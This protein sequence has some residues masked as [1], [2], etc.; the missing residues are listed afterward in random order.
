MAEFAAQEL[1]DYLEKISSARVPVKATEVEDPAALVNIA[2]A[3]VIVTGED[4]EPYR[5]TASPV[6]PT[7]WLKPI[8]A[9]LSGAKEDSLAIRNT[10]SRSALA[11]TNDRGTLYAAYELLEREGVRFFAPEFDFYEGHSE[12][13]PHRST[14]EVGTLRVTEQPS[15]ALRRKFVGQGISHDTTKLAQLLDWMAKQRLNILVYPYNNHGG[16]TIKWDLY[17]EPLVPE[18]ERRSMI[19]EVGGHG[20]HSFLP[21]DEYKDEHPEWFEDGRNVFDVTNEEAVQTYIDN[22]IAYL[23]G[24]PEIKIFD[25]WPPDGARWPQKAIDEFGSIPNAEAHLINELNDQMQQRLP[26]VTVENIA[27]QPA[28]E[29]PDPEYMYDDEVIID[30]APY[31][32]SYTEPIF[33]PTYDK[34]RDF[35]ELM[36]RWESSGFGGDKAIYEY[37][38]KYSWHSLPNEFPDLISQEIPFYRAAGANGFGIYSEPADWLAYELNHLLVAVLSWNT[39]LD[40]EGIVDNY[41]KDRY[42]PAAGDMQIYIDLVEEAGRALFDR[43]RGNYEDPQAVTTAYRN[44]LAARESLTAAASKAGQH[45]G[46]GHVLKGRLSNIAFAI[47][48]T[49][50]AYYEVLGQQTDSVEAKRRTQELVEAQY[51][52]GVGLKGWFGLRRYTTTQ[53]GPLHRWLF[54]MYRYRADHLE[55][56]APPSRDVYLS[57]L[58][59]VY[60]VSGVGSVERDRRRRGGPITFDGQTYDKGLGVHAYSEVGYHL[61]EN[62]LEFRADVGIDDSAG[63]R[64]SVIFQVWSGNDKLYDSGVLTGASD[65]KRVAVDVSEARDLRLIVSDAGDGIAWDEADWADAQVTCGA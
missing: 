35:S 31:N 40:S 61:G 43:P 28:L 63:D 1:Q 33:G 23:E 5:R 34:N 54:D 22:V 30:F 25:A 13:I 16:D 39:E 65:S 14:I 18:F 48:D 37:Y 57:D 49:E 64:G 7:G 26:R 4:A 44:Y 46:T 17:R 38:T 52:S 36:E 59:W 12:H 24:R 50:I 11:G 19:V 15:L 8:D 56:P 42:G 29:P 6:V 20:Y 45:P 27:Y 51:M 62:C 55:P 58:D 41:L 9:Q 2:S 21:P 47:A 60:A 10:G 53:S 32:R 3:V